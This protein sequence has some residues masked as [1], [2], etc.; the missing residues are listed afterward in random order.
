M[1]IGKVITLD[2][3]KDYLLLEKVELNSKEYL[4]LVEVDK[5]DIPTTNYLFLE[6][7][8]ESD[9]DY[10]EEVEDK[11]IIEALTSMLTVKYIN[12]SMID[13]DEQAA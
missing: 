2:N 12:D 13:N 1:D 8:H 10:T 5:D 4:Y 6:L 11:D 3:N 9:G 7:T